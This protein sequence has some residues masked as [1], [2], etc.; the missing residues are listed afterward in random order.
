MDI[1]ST[2]N[3]LW[4][5]VARARIVCIVVN[6][7]LL[8]AKHDDYDCFYTIGGKV[9]ANET[10]AD[11]AIREAYEET[12]Y[13]FTVDRLVYVQERFYSAD[14]TQHHEVTFFYLM[15]A[16]DTQIENGSCTAHLKERLYWLP[17]DELQKINLVPK[18]LRTALTTI[19]DDPVHIISQEQLKT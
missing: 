4:H 19:P 12:G 1:H 18:F 13:H 10:S 17:I 3:A 14:D 9:K 2:E 8:V 5:C 16:N 11:A 15:E 7:Q 6:N